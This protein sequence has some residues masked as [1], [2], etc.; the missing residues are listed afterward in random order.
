MGGG[1]RPPPCPGQWGGG[2]ST[3]PVPPPLPPSRSGGLSRARAA[4]GRPPPPQQPPLPSLAERPPTS[5]PDVF[6]RISRCLSP[7][8]YLYLFPFQAVC[9]YFLFFVP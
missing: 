7:L 6:G 4:A 5:L 1:L 9:L 8:V 3:G 2:R